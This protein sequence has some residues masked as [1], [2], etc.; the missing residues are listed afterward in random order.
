MRI[1]TGAGP[2]GEAQQQSSHHV[3]DVRSGAIVGTYHFSGAA[4]KS[5]PERLKAI[6]KSSH[7][8]AGVPLE[9]LAVLSNADV[10]LGDGEL[11]IEPAAKQLVRKAGKFD[12]RVLS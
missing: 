9:H 10:P 6:L 3:Y 5:E 7:E 2:A 1:G 4:P 12:P 11:S 8:A